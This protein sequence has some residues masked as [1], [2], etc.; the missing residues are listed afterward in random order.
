MEIY[1]KGAILKKSKL[2]NLVAND[3][4]S[5]AY[6]HAAWMKKK[7]WI[8]ACKFSATSEGNEW[9]WIIYRMHG[10]SITIT[11]CHIKHRS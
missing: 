5:A 7:E 11:Y 10:I 2:S 3:I 9:K 6:I 8:C 1:I 4:N